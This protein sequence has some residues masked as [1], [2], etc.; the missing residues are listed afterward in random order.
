MTSS[1]IYNKPAALK[2]R[3]ACV[4][5]MCQITLEIYA[6]VK[7]KSVVL[8]INWRSIR[9]IMSNYLFNQI[10]PYISPNVHADIQCSSESIFSVSVQHNVFLCLRVGGLVKWYLDV[11]F[12]QRYLVQLGIHLC[13]ICAFLICSVA[14]HKHRLHYSHIWT[15]TPCCLHL[16]VCCMHG[17]LSLY[18][19]VAC[20]KYGYLFYRCFACLY[21]TAI[22]V[23]P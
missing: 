2:L 13:R 10:F 1:V 17:L 11:L 9:N 8:Y 5:L 14:N 20:F 7:L 12:V 23:L 22:P 3:H 15:I 6:K 4:P 21:F 16:G 18:G 19:N